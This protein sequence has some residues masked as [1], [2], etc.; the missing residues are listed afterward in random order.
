ML[1]QY[2]LYNQTNTEGN[3]TEV[4]TV[5]GPLDCQPLNFHGA[6]Q[7]PWTQVATLLL[8]FVLF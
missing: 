5:T 8:P 7:G 4:T 2:Q 3:Q 1:D 6:N